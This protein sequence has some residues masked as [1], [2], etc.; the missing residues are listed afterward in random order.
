M[1]QTTLDVQLFWAAF[2]CY[3]LGWLS[4][5]FW[6]G[7]KK[8]VLTKLGSALF[9]LGFIPQTI[10]FVLRWIHTG[11][12]PMSNMYEYIAVMSWM[13]VVSLGIL[14]YKYRNWLISALI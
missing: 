12:Y 1:M 5:S 3:G 9:V 14:T 10:G 8:P 13:A 2:I 7:L 11:H 6:L 4:F